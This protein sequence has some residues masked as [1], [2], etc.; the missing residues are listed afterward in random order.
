MPV[1]IPVRSER[2]VHREGLAAAFIL[3]FSQVDLLYIC[4][5]DCKISSVRREI[6]AITTVA[7]CF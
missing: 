6:L 7:Y 2:A 5:F 4:H 3:P 1:G